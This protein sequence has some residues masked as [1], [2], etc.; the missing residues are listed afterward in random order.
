MADLAGGLVD[1][2]RLAVHIDSANLEAGKELVQRL[3]PRV[4]DSEQWQQIR[5]LYW[6]TLG[7]RAE[8]DQVAA[9]LLDGDPTAANGADAKIKSLPVLGGLHHD[10]Q[11]AA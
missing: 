6:G 3:D 11:R 5:V 8:L 2:L 1:R 7:N 10:Y 9:R 4:F